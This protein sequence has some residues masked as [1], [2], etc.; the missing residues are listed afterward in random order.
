MLPGALQQFTD[1]E[2]LART[3]ATDLE[4]AVPHHT[5][6]RP[7]GFS[8]ARISDRSNRRS[9][10]IP[11]EGWDPSI[12]KANFTSDRR[13]LEISEASGSVFWISVIDPHW[14]FKHDDGQDPTPLIRWH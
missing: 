13:V 11:L 3:L 14:L 8:A 9:E 4:R 6:L 5:S 7:H 12:A 2:S 10:E 1:S